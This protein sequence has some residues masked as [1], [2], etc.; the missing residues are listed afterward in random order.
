VKVTMDRHAFA[1]FPS[2]NG[3][4]VAPQVRRDF[5]PGLDQ[6]GRR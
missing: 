2:L 1:A 6:I 3:R 4:H 5:F